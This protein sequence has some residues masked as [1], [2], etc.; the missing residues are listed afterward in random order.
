MISRMRENFGAAG[1]VVAIVALVAALA[2]GAIAANGGGA[3]TASKGKAGPRG[4]TGKTG[5]A[6]PAGPAGPQGTAGAT[7]KEGSNGTNGTNGAP[8]APG[9]DGES[10]VAEPASAADCPAGGTTFSVGA[11]EETVCSGEEGP[12]GPPGPITNEPVPAGMTMSGLASFARPASGGLAHTTIT[13]PY[14]L[15][16]PFALFTET[17]SVGKYKVVPTAEAETPGAVAGCPGTFSDPRAESKYFC[18]YLSEW[19]NLASNAM[20]PSADFSAFSKSGIGFY[21][22]V[23]D[24][25]DVNKLDESNGYAAWAYQP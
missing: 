22:Y 19:V 9:D 5:P 20:T 6:G 25:A 13:F 4:K 17:I 23:E 1:L 8:G 16:N 15:S 3:A 7:G 10:V 11:T 24:P 12:Q 18:W 2:G 21:A 14:R